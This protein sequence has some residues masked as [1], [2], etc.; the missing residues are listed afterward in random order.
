MALPS[1]P[2]P[3]RRRGLAPVAVVSGLA[4]SVLLS[5]SLTGSLS[6]FTA[7]ITNDTNT[8]GAGT[9]VMKEIRTSGTGT[10]TCTST[11]TN[12]INTNAYTS[13]SSINKYGGLTNMVPGDAVMT[14]VT[15]ENTGT[16]AIKKFTLT[17]GTCTQSN[18]GS[19]NGNAT[20]LCAR[21]NVRIQVTGGG[22]LIYNG[23]ASAMTTTPRVVTV[24]PA[25]LSGAKS[26]IDITVTLDATAGNTYQGLQASQPLTWTFSSDA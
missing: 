11:D 23:A 20:D 19:P 5:L 18:N 17:P 22:Q 14:T 10:P 21:I 6:A 8:A 1:L 2:H 26:I 9:V 3:R 7:G 25:P 13:C 16:A 4:G 12:S 24:L 15:I